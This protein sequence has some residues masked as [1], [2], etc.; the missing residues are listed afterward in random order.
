MCELK[1]FS[2]LKLDRQHQ[3]ILDT[4]LAIWHK[5]YLTK[6]DYQFGKDETVLD[7]GA[8]NGETAQFYLNHG[9]SHVISVEP[10]AKLLYENFGN[11]KRV[12]IV[13][14]AVNIIKID[15]EGCERNMVV[16][17]H[18]VPLRWK[19]LHRYRT[20]FGRV[21]RLEEDWGSPITK[22]LRRVGWKMVDWGQ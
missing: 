12:L 5:W 16:E 2:H 19:V 13:P 14:L 8:G 17:S 6:P 9:A 7:V 3:Y 1:D 10:E 4:E 11:D 20:L 22:L 21:W 15:G 18:W